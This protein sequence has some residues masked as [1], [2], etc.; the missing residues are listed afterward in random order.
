[1][2]IS[3]LPKFIIRKISS[4]ETYQYH[5]NVLASSIFVLIMLFVI[6]HLDILSFLPGFCIINKTFGIPCPGCGITRSLKSLLQ[7]NI[8]DS[9][10]YNPA[11]IIVFFCFFVQIP[12]RATILLS[13][14]NIHIIETTFKV[15]NIIAIASI[16]LVW[17]ERVVLKIL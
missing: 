17:I 4:D 16:L 2:E 9:W 15:I 7:F 10:V 13:R 14:K 8:I 1:M 3:I 11:G 12:L 6:T 5:I